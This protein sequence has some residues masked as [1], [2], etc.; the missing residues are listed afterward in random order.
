MSVQIGEQSEAVE[1]SRDGP[2][3]LISIK[4]PENKNE[5][6]VFKNTESGLKLKQTWNRIIK[7]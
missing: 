5:R 7:F 4:V 1:L 3:E 6:F 2:G